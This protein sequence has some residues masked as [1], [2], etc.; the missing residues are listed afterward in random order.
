M[1]DQLPIR[2]LIVD[3]QQSICRLCVTIGQAM[4]LV[5][6]QAESAELALERVENE[7][8]ELVIADLEIGKMSGLELLAAVKQRSPLTEVALMSAYGTTESAVQAMRLGAYDFVVKPF[9]VEKF[10]QILQRMVEK[11]RLVREN[12]LLRL[13]VRNETQ[14]AATEREG[15]AEALSSDLGA[16]ERQTVQRVFEQVDGDKE[17]A[18]KLLGISRATLYRKIKRYGIQARQA[19][20][21]GLDIRVAKRVIPLSQS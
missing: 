4:G 17:L 3:G 6:S 10:K 13:R 21:T 9:R 5:C 14:G 19:K 12:E 1:C 20:I 11:V 18:Q 15:G 16:L 7:V 2:I 8:P